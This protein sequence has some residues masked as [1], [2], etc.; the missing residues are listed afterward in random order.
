MRDTLVVVG[1]LHIGST[2]GLCLGPVG[3]DNGGTYLPSKAQN[4]LGSCW[5]SFWQEVQETRQGDLYVVFNGDSVDSDHHG[6]FEL[7]AK[8]PKTQLAMAKEYLKPIV[9]MAD[10][11]FFVRGT[12]VHDGGQ[13]HWQEDLAESLGGVPNKAARTC[14]WYRLAL[15]VN[16]TLVSVRHHPATA[17]RRPWTKGAASNRMAAWLV[18]SYARKRL[19][20]L[21]IF[22]H[23]H[24]TEDSGDTHPVRVVYAPGWQLMTEYGVRLGGDDLSPPDIGG[25]IVQ[26]PD[27]GKFQLTVRTYRPQTAAPWRASTKTSSRKRSE[28]RSGRTRVTARTMASEA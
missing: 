13:G 6:T 16:G 28:E 9:E 11:A 20:D 4:W 14:S 23:V 8:N 18:Y 25:I 1:D 24:Y 10:Y 7:V 27:D 21:A 19:P 3:L 15:E 5:G 17:S 22:S 12:P 2:V 26:C